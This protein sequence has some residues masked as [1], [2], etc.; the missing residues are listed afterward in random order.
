[1]ILGPGGLGNQGHWLGGGWPGWAREGRGFNAPEEGPIRARIRNPGGVPW[2]GLFASGPGEATGKKEPDA[3]QGPDA[4][5][6][7]GDPVPG[8][9]IP[10]GG[11]A[12]RP[13]QGQCLGLVRE[14]SQLRG[15][16]L[17]WLLLEDSP[18]H[19]G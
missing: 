16:A 7:G 5:T 19:L 12:R 1:M 9:R 3:G 15:P 6:R 11:H 2:D 4:W 18:Q 8:V 14:G 17:S 10:G 13:R